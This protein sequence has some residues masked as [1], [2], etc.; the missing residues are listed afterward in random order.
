MEQNVAAF[1]RFAL[2]V[3]FKATVLLGIT[4]VA[5]LLLRR[6]SAAARQLAATLGLAGALLLPAATVVAP[7]WEL[8][9]LPSPVPEARSFSADALTRAESPAPFEEDA[10][11][12]GRIERAVST[13][14]PDLHSSDG[15]P[16]PAA[17]GSAEIPRPPAPTTPL[18]PMAWMLAILGLWAAGTGLALIRLALGAGRVRRVCR[19]ASPDADPSWMA[20]AAE[21]STRLGL[22]RPVRR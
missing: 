4:A 5:L 12:S 7:H 18:S 20:I 19:R 15:A 14:E 6:A 11:S 17:A 8:P 10:K 21:L 1:A 22:R 9:L 16:A 2:D 3:A 13:G